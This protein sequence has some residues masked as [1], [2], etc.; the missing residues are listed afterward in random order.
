MDV[1]LNDDNQMKLDLDETWE[2]EYFIF[3]W[4]IF[5]NLDELIVDEGGCIMVIWMYELRSSEWTEIGW[6]KVS[7]TTFG[8]V[9]DLKLDSE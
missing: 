8:S 6:M 7:Q 9:H 1:I 3:G 4:M 2:D 5:A